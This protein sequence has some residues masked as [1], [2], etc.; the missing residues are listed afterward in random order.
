VGPTFYGNKTAAK[1]TSITEAVTTYTSTSKID[2]L[3]A[4]T[5][6]V[7]PNPSADLL[8][9]QSS[10]L[11]SDNIVANLINAD[12]KI[13]QSQTILQGSTL[14]YFDVSTLYSGT[15]FVRIENGTSPKT[16]SV[17]VTK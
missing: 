5:F 11:H 9:V 13:L 12:G 4:M 2:E 17:V 8:V 16:F 10:G 3:E 15:Y 1:V 6:N 14:C 7:F